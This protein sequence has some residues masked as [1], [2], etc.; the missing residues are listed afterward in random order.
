LADVAARYLEQTADIDLGNNM[1]N[2][3]GGVHAAALGSL[4][5]AV[6]FGVAGVRP[7]PSNEETLLI[8]PHLLPGWRHL[9]FPLSWRGS[10]LAV[11]LEPSALEVAVTGERPARVAL[12]GERGGATVSIVVEPG[13]RYVARLDGRQQGGWQEAGL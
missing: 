8:E 2:A 5:Q 4:W 3:A 10:Q 9:G 13:R 1:G 11:P 12:G 6:V 7:C